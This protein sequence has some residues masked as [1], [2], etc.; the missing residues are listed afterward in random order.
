MS[1]PPTCGALTQQ[2]GLTIHASA[3]AEILLRGN[4]MNS[5]PGKAPL[6]LSIKPAA[7]AGRRVKLC[8]AP[9]EPSLL[10]HQPGVINTEK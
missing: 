6:T 9:W 7:M 10:N 4:R 2:Y 8:Y 1:G 5:S 3:W